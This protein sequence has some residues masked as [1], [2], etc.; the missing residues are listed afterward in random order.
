M[1]TVRAASNTD[2]GNGVRH[3]CLKVLDCF[4]RRTEIVCVS[5][6]MCVCVCVHK[7]ICNRLLHDRNAVLLMPLH[8]FLFWTVTF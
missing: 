1:R 5:L 7:M 6:R 2:I 8:L 3:R 4:T